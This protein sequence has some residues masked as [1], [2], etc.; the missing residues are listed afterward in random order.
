[1]VESSD[2]KLQVLNQNLWLYQI[3]VA[4]QHYRRGWSR[5][6]VSGIS[7]LHLVSGFIE[8]RVLFCPG[9]QRESRF[10]TRC[11][12]K[13]IPPKIEF[14][15]TDAVAPLNDMFASFFP[16]VRLPP[17]LPPGR[18]LMTQVASSKCFTSPFA[19]HTRFPSALTFFVTDMSN[20]QT[21]RI[22]DSV[23][24]IRQPGFCVL[25]S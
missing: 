11:Y 7:I 3:V 12:A 4:L 22:G 20:Y 1:M 13:K 14:W 5:F 16:V 9:K 23:Q 21:H 17:P 6:S 2:V 24:A 25:F 15:D 19:V 8:M 10:L 18:N